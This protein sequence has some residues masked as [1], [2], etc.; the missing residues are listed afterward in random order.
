[1]KLGWGDNQQKNAAIKIKKKNI[2][3]LANQQLK[4]TKLNIIGS[5]PSHSL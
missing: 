4:S 5:T 1:M 3:A 2:E